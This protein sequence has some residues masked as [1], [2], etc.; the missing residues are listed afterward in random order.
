MN[1]LETELVADSRSPPVL[2]LAARALGMLAAL[3]SVTGLLYPLLVTA[4]AQVV[5]PDQ[6]NG[7]L[8]REGETT[9]G[10]RLIG[11]PFD[12]P[13]YFWGRP[14][15]TTPAPYNG[16][17]SAASNLGPTSGALT[18]A[19]AARVEALRRADPGNA[20]PIPVDLVTSSAS[21]LDPHVTPAAALYQARRVARARGLDEGRVRQLVRA[22]TEDRTF[23]VLGEPRVNVLLLNRSLDE[24]AATAARTGRGR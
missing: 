13:G 3:T 23:G 1:S 7:S 20:A 22:H 5:F 8:I 4:L 11:Q 24:L 2:S 16:G 10:S 6:A 19:A 18:R 14:S 15:A 9:V 21:G 12:E 17:S